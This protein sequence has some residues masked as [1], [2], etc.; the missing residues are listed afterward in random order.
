MKQYRIFNIKYDTD[1]NDVKLPNQMFVTFEVDSEDVE[2]ELSDFI[3]RDTG[4]CHFG[5]EFEEITLQEH[6]LK[7]SPEDRLKI[8]TEGSE[9]ELRESLLQEM[10]ELMCGF[11]IDKLY[12]WVSDLWDELTDEEV[13]DISKA[14]EI[15]KTHLN[16]TNN[17]DDCDFVFHHD[18]LADEIHSTDD[19]GFQFPKKEN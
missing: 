13:S 14:I 17:R 1:G 5:F 19:W 15:C 12:Y 6:L 8:S 9:F 7:C 4:F 11:N 10:W 3:S 16:F 2:E 18:P